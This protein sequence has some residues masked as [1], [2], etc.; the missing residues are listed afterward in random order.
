LNVEHVG[1]AGSPLPAVRSNVNRG[2]HGVTRPT[3]R[4]IAGADDLHGWDYFDGSHGSNSQLKRRTWHTLGGELKLDVGCADLL[5][6]FTHH[7]SGEFG[8]VAFT[9]QVGEVEVFQFGGHDLRGGFGGGLVREMAV[10]SENALLQAPRAVDTILQQ[11]HIMIGFEDED[12]RGARALNDQF[13]HVT[14][15]GDETDVAGGGV[16][17]KADGV[18]GVVRD[19]ERVHRHIADFKART[20]LEQLAIEFGFQ[21]RFKRFLR[22]AIAVNRDVQFG[23]DSGQA[24]NVVVMFVR[25]ENGSEIFR[26]TTNGGEPLADL[27]WAEPGVHKHAGFVGLKIGA[28]AAR[29][30]AENGEFD[31]HEC[32]LVAREQ[33]GKLISMTAARQEPRPTRLYPV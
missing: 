19:G 14:E 15:V 13:R 8:L 21:L 17:Q 11:L 4:F 30:A 24:V 10:A 31:G 1:R 20:S 7:P 9:A 28:V 16:Q 6:L 33:R 32:T 27:T 3:L 25:D 18:L 26:Y 12:V 23:G 2:A 22:G 5:E 29:T